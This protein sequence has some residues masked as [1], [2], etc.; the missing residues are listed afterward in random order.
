MAA[1]QP[2]G[3]HAAKLLDYLRSRLQQDATVLY[4]RWLRAE[5]Q[6]HTYAEL[7]ALTPSCSQQASIAST[8]VIPPPG[9]RPCCD[10][11]AMNGPIAVPGHPTTVSPLPSHLPRVCTLAES[12][13][14]FARKQPLRQLRFSFTPSH[15]ITGVVTTNNTSNA[16]ALLGRQQ[17][18]VV[19]WG[20]EEGPVH[21]H[22]RAD[23][24]VCIVLVPCNTC[25]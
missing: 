10:Q 24:L 17:L 16:S 22:R 20:S 2:D 9:Q 6:A 21:Q 25:C 3:T 19:L 13:R 14:H 11:D 4:S 12:S 1:S 18:S 23:S 7:L 8:R 15:Q 5:R